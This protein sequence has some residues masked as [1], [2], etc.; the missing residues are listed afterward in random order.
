MNTGTLL[1]PRMGHLA[2]LRESWTVFMLLLFLSAPPVTP[3]LSEAFSFSSVLWD[4]GAGHYARIFLAKMC[5]A[6]SRLLP[7]QSW[8]PLMQAQ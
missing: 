4:A 3:R 1:Q 6:A 8:I 7:I 5:Q 2:A